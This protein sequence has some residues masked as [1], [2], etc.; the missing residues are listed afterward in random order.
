MRTEFSSIIGELNKNNE[1]SSSIKGRLWKDIKE[2]V[3][4]NKRDV[5]EALKENENFWIKAIK[6]EK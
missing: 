2:M 5:N 3:E 4:E 6:E 1:E